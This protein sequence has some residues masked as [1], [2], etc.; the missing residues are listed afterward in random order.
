MRA[1]HIRHVLFLVA[2]L[3][4]PVQAEAF[5]QRVVSVS[6]C[7]DEYVYRLLPRGRI[8]ALSFLAGDRHPVVSTIV[9]AV[10]GIPLIH[11]SAEEV[12]DRNPDLVVMSAATEARL[13]AQMVT[14]GIRV[15]DVP[16]TATLADIRSATLSLG[17]ALG[18]RQRARSML[19]SMDAQLAEA[20]FTGRKV[21]TLIY[22]PNGYASASGVTDAIMERAGLENAAGSMG[23]TRSGTIPPEAIMA[24]PP[25]LLILNA[26]PLERASLAERVLDHP[27]LAQLKRRI[28]VARIPLTPLLCP[29]PW[30]ASVV[31]AF[32]RL[33][34]GALAHSPG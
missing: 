20:R 22:E 16:W 34:A 12:L 4:V 14:A 17:Q 10:K 11:A 32:V 33:R 6:L 18:E 2:A 7:T 5:P 28:D 21:R 24:R 3:A 29:G 13:H 1:T 23:A 19:Q 8:A 25:A 30:S 15:L 26:S 31:P 9:D 27:A